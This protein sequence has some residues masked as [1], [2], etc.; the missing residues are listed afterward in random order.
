[1]KTLRSLNPLNILY[2]LLA[3]IAVLVPVAWACMGTPPPPKCARSIYLAK[4]VPSTVVVHALNRP[5]K[6]PIGIQP[7][8]IW[9]KDPRCPRPATAE[10]SL[11][12]TCT[13]A[14]GGAPVVIGPQTFPLPKPK[15]CGLQPTQI[16][17]FIIPAN[18]LAGPLP[19]RCTV[20]GTYTVTF[21]GGTVPQGSGPLSATGDTTVCLVQPSTYDPRLPRLEVNYLP[22]DPKGEEL[23]KI[24]RRGDQ[25][26]LWFRIT[27][28]DPREAATLDLASEG[29]QTAQLPDG[30]DPNNPGAAFDASVFAISSPI[31][32]TDTF[33]AEFTDLLNPGDILPEPD[34]S[35]V[36]PLRI[37]RSGVVIPPLE[38]SIVGI[39]VRSHG[40]CADGSCNERGLEVSGFFGDPGDNDI[41]LGCASTLLV[42]GDSRAKSP[43]VE[44]Q[45]LLKCGP[46]IDS[47]WGR[48]EYRDA[49]TAVIPHSSTHAV[50]NLRNIVG[51]QLTGAP[52]VRRFQ[53]FP[54]QYPSRA[55]DSLRT[56][57][58][59]AFAL[60]GM[61]AFPSPNFS[62]VQNNVQIHGLNQVRKGQRVA[63]P[64]ILPNPLPQSGSDTFNIIYNAA[65]DQLQVSGSGTSGPSSFNGK[66]KDF[67]RR[68][69]NGMKADRST[70]RTFICSGDL[71]QPVIGTIP[72]AVTHTTNRPGCLSFFDV[73]LNDPADRF[74]GPPNGFGWTASPRPIQGHSVYGG[75]RGLLKTPVTILD[76]LRGSN[77]FGPDN[78]SIVHVNV[79]GAINSPH[80]V[81]V[82]TRVLPD[83]CLQDGNCHV[84]VN[85]STGQFTVNEPGV[86]AGGG[87]GRVTRKGN[88]IGLTGRAN[89]LPGGSFNVDSFFDIFVE[90][91]V[92]NRNGMAE[93]T[94][95][96][97]PPFT[98]TDTDA[99][100]TCP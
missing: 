36:D 78:H 62:T 65:T 98:V 80:P 100:A 29:N 67:L 83:V 39:T 51:T 18:A 5:I 22:T 35:D 69:P 21:G 90:I 10:V 47:N 13:P 44:I 82:H 79:P 81:P 20:V 38:S 32:G 60:Y 6:V 55:S 61:Q 74:L 41:A 28:N 33:P 34:P 87:V 9:D 17:D 24:C 72:P 70:C 89:V 11:T 25:G 86:I 3:A 75:N 23:F 77:P 27:N 96:G 66:L 42:V 64:L 94:P 54:N 85:T 71:D 43:L 95:S 84:H 99:F 49:T 2:P 1:M 97:Q 53:E 73:F 16:I 12:L 92:D 37:S 40:M 50:G 68:P 26:I 56:D 88:M 4:F 48:C 30:F 59:P 57:V 19:T 7:F 52:L 14:G 93:I 46:T 91:N 58:Q 63:M 15:N 8:L 76:T 45:D 31:P